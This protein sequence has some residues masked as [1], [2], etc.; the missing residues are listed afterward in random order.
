MRRV[1]VLLLLSGYWLPANGFGQKTAPV[2]L[3]GEIVIFPGNFQAVSQ[4]PAVDVAEIVNGYYFRYLQCTE[5]PTARQRAT[6]EAQGVQFIGYLPYGVYLAAL[7][8]SFDLRQLEAIGVRGILPVN[9]DWKMAQSLKE[10]PYGDWAV[11]GDLVDVDVQVYPVL[12]ITEAAARLRARGVA[13]R[14]AGNQNGFIGIRV[15][16]NSL[17][18]IAA[19][20]FVRYLELA[21]EPP[22]PDDERGRAIHR[23][24]L[25]DADSPLG[26]QYDGA[27]VSVLV[28][29]D[30]RAG[31]HIDFQGR[32]FN[33]TS[34]DDAD[35]HSD[36][37]GGVVGGAGNLNPQ[38]RG[39]ATG[40]DLYFMDYTVNFQD[41]TLP[42]HLNK[43]I[44][45]TNTSYT[46]GC[47][48]GY[49]LAAQ[50]V[51][52]QL[53]ENP[54][55]MHVFSAG[56]SGTDNCNY[57]A[58]AGWGNVTGGHKMAKNATVVASVDANLELSYF[59]SRGPA[60]DGRLKPDIAGLGSGVNMPVSGNDYISSNGTSYSAPAVAGCM[61]QL[62]QAYKAL[63]NGQQPDAAL[64]KLALLN[65]A[66]DLGN[67]GPDF[68]FGWGLMDA[69][70][71]WRL[72]ENGRWAQGQTEQNQT[73]SHTVAIPPGTRQARIM[74]YWLDPPAALNASKTLVN[75]LDLTVLGPGGAIFL[76]WKPDPTPDPVIL[77]TPAGKG[78][79]SLNNVEQVVIDDPAAGNY[80]VRINGFEVPMGPQ[81]YVVAWEFLT[82]DVKITYP[83][84]G[85]ALV[86]GETLRIQWDAL[87][88]SPGFTLRYSTDDAQSW[89]PIN[90]VGGANRFF[91]WTVPDLVN[92]NI[93]FSVLRSN[94]QDT[95][96]APLTIAPVPTGLRID[97]VCPDSITLAW[98]RV[99]DTLQYDVYLLGAKY[100][101][102][103]GTT[104][105]SFLTLPVQNAGAEQW[106][107]VRAAYPGG[108]AGRRAIAVGWPGGL[109]NCPQPDDVAMDTLLS[110]PG[111]ALVA[112][113]PVEDSVSVRMVN[114]GVNAISGATLFYQLNAEPPV[115]EPLPD[116]P[117]GASLTFTFQNKLN[118]TQNGVAALKVWSSYAA[119]DARFNDTLQI[120]FPVFVEPFD[121]F[122]T[123]TF[124]NAAF[125]P[126]GW[127][128]ENPDG[129]ITWTRPGFTII[130]PEGQPT[131]AAYLNCFNYNENGERDYLCLPSVDLSKITHPGLTFDL[132]HAIFEPGFSETL[133]I[134]VFPDCDL[135]AVPTVIWAKTDPALATTAPSSGAFIPDSSADWRREGASLQKFAGQR[136]LIRFALTNGFGNNLYLDNIGI[137]EFAPPLAAIQPVPDTVCRTPQTVTFT[138]VP[139]GAN[140]SYAWQFGVGALPASTASGLGPHVVSFLTAGNKNVRL[141]VT[142]SGFS[143]TANQALY[144]VGFPQSN[145]TVAAAGATAT[146]TNTSQHADTY[147]WNFGDDSTSTEVNPVHQYALP[148]TYTVTLTTENACTTTPSVKTQ[149]IV[150]D[151]VGT[152]ELPEFSDIRV[153]PNPTAGDFRV[154]MRAEKA[155]ETRLTLL[156]IAG[157]QIKTVRTTAGPGLTSVPFEDLRL[158]GGIYRL[159]VQTESGFRVFSVAVQ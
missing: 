19:L 30:G 41:E 154:E 77:N 8:E 123:E 153:A 62:A 68:R 34:N 104:A 100:M 33:Q 105:D 27:G 70:R 31:P 87:G 113:G 109:K 46:D 52:K 132:A 21:P 1:L 23:A 48:K 12:R 29:D 137:G 119:E 96:D 102:I 58:G 143:D 82:D 133:R 85:E 147:L 115:G 151:F 18:D 142:E 75:D 79:D 94:K 9:P 50:T 5:I 93:R 10:T 20:P 13:V 15:A 64:L 67:P 24:N 156:D 78:R 83:A 89:I 11:H 69:G 44:T 55:L 128:I 145:F 140:A 107:S 54:T 144:V 124:E 136:V 35:D 118:I 150:L 116:I 25:L 4:N 65:T 126:E 39:M 131:R 74:V 80:E 125:P 157:R 51:D 36:Q 91:N 141:I 42:L 22:K 135:N 103:A 45:V 152:N 129:E 122:F 159:Y 26:K 98:N 56:N 76:P 71:A 130:G 148:G 38:F 17:R 63:H 53:F 120:S 114:A 134:E 97:K 110:P 7:P 117:A 40:A 138:A 86:P 121:T 37:V 66:T 127:K 112:C 73:A 16:Q 3:N 60:H 95:T 61:A 47:N 99:N 57:G 92:A 111:S 28:R 139:D 108:L 146:F 49:S 2:R 106:A 158:P 101:E 90:I 14:E 43:N 149:T 84:G 88:T 155:T 32:S 81:A 6:L 72:L 59:S